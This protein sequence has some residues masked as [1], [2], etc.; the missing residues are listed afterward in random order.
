MWVGIF[1]CPGKKFNSFSCGALFHR[2]EFA[3]G[4]VRTAT[5]GLDCGRH[6]LGCGTPR[7]T[8]ARL[9][10]DP[11]SVNPRAETGRI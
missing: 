11:R 2:H 6:R 10:K 4:L 8:N 1:R 5:R 9:F 3:V 7:I